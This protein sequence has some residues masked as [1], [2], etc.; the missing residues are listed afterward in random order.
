MDL[1]APGKLA[2]IL[3]TIIGCF[4]YIIAGD[5]DT[6]PA[7]ATITMLSG[8]LIGNGAGAKN[9][10]PQAPVFAPKPDGNP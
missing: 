8:Y 2:V 3:V 5:G 7:W 4:A 9:G 6:T 1:T 10:V